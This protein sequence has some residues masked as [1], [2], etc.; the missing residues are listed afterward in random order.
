[1]Q[2]RL[3]CLFCTI[4]FLIPNVLGSGVITDCFFI[5][6]NTDSVELVCDALKGSYPENDCFLRLFSLDTAFSN[7][8]A[9]VK[10]LKTGWCTSSNLRRRFFESFTKLRI[11][12]LSYFGVEILSDL[13]LKYLQTFNASHNKITTIKATNFR[14]MPDIREIDL[15]FNEISTLE[16]GTFSRLRDLRILNLSFNLIEKIDHDSFKNNKKLEILQL[17]N[18]PIK[19]ID[20]NIFLLLKR[21]VS[22]NV[23]WDKVTEIDTSCLG[24]ALR[25][26]FSQ[27]HE[28]FFRVP[29]RGNGLKCIG[30]VFQHLTYLNVSG[31][32]LENATKIVELLGDSIEVLDLASNFMGNSCLKEMSRCSVNGG[33][34]QRFINLKVLNLSRTNL[35]HFEVEAFQGMKKLTTLDLSFNQLKYLDFGSVILND[36]NTL[37]LG[38]NQLIEIKWIRQYNLPKLTYLSIMGNNFSCEYLDELMKKS[39]NLHLTTDSLKQRDGI[40]CKNEIRYSERS[41]ENIDNVVKTTDKWP[42]SE[43]TERIESTQTIGIIAKT[44]T[45]KIAGETEA[46]K[47][48]QMTESNETTDEMITTTG[49][50]FKTEND[51]TTETINTTKSTEL[52]IITTEQNMETTAD[53]KN[54]DDNEGDF[55][56]DEIHSSSVNTEITITDSS[57]LATDSNLYDNIETTTKIAISSIMS[58]RDFSKSFDFAP[59]YTHRRKNVRKIS[60]TL[61]T[62]LLLVSFLAICIGFLIVRSKCTGRF[63][64]NLKGNSK[65]MHIPYRLDQLDDYHNSVEL[66]DHLDFRQWHLNTN[67][68]NEQCEFD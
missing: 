20:S 31:N 22:V 63:K 45:M 68:N 7:Y 23:S 47:T 56:S 67:I 43:T 26:E 4:S 24:T 5:N 66:I 30:N 29:Y 48:T 51:E 11:I 61:T 25:I 14:Q 37:K 16:F 27:N 3:L 65:R 42:D 21:S 28:I 17:E 50:A 60:S 8:R 6:N 57:T 33:I 35:T 55:T 52:T 32:H 36:L 64:R 15:S 13:R 18:N 44:K 9:N 58:H 62:K 10:H 1:M 40:D 53:I 59:K 38:G 46:I 41:T 34:F 12:D 49:K 19:R 2:C 54:E 39:S